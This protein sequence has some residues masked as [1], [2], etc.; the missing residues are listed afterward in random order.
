[1]KSEFIP[2][3][4]TCI[5]FYN[6]E[7]FK[8]DLIAGL[9]IGIVSIPLAIAF[10][11][12]SGS[13]PERG[14]IT[15]I[16]AG[17]LISALGGSRVQ[18]GGPTG[19]F[20]VLIYDIIQ[21][22]G[23]EGL[24]VA[25]L[26]AAVLLVLF[27]VLRL[28]KWIKY[29]PHPLV[30]GFTTGLA[31]IIFSAQIKDFLGFTPSCCAPD[32]IAK[33]TYYIQALPT[34]HLPTLFLGLGSLLFII[35]IRHYFPKWPWG[36]LVIGIATCGVYLFHL[37]VATVHS[38]FGTLP[39]LF[40]SLSW[41]QLSTVSGHLPALFIDGLAIAL[42]GGIESLLC[43]VIADGM[44]GGRHRSNCELIGQGIA[45]FAS[46]ICG[47]IPATGAIARTATNI[48]AGAQTPIAGMI[49]AVTV[50][51][52]VAFFASAV[53]HIPLATLSAVL[54][55]VAWNM[56]EISHF[57]YLLRAPYADVTILL[58]GFILTVF[59]DITSAITFGMILA[60]L[61]FM[62]KMSA[63]THATSELDQ[64]ES[65]PQVPPDVEVY[66]IQGPFFF[67]TADLLQ[68]ILSTIQHPPRLFILRLGKALFIDTSALCAL[69]EFHKRCSQKGTR[70]LLS[71]VHGQV[72]KDLD[73]LHLT[74]LMGK[75]NIF[76][77]LADALAIATAPKETASS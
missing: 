39:H 27:G 13:T 21:R 73:R 9:T 53:G 14:L 60:S 43:A 3:L 19:A 56:S 35:L 66:A 30:T 46:I 36:V 63:H 68:D 6:R 18:I 50:L 7:T 29:V 37:D 33:W 31:L 42:L 10:A 40:T 75:E 8:K 76:P 67:G 48:K 4:F 47:G 1:M 61:I 20:V 69:K 44:I 2:K 12:A 24:A 16:V 26:I 49:H 25:T 71:D 58:S 5:P 23:Y 52:F 59:V 38:K 74:S 17:F 64:S 41:P 62:K 22:R 57:L 65:A 15:A 51:I 77:T 28:G 72:K 11:I 54:I 70:L 34:T 32:F 45:N 55:M